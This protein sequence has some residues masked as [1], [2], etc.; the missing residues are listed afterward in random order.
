MNAPLCYSG[1]G[2]YIAYTAPRAEFEAAEGIREL[3]RDVYLPLEQRRVVRRNRRIDVTEPLFRRYVFFSLPVGD[4]EWGPVKHVDGVEDV[5]CNRGRASRVPTA[6]IER[7]RMLEKVGA[8][9]RTTP[10]TAYGI[11]ERVRVAEGPF[12]GLYA[13][14][15]EFI[16][17]MRSATARK[18]VKVLLN[19]LG[20]KSSIELDVDALEKL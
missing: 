5:L 12:T 4:D 2:W 6:A 10:L 14:I 9:N 13:E 17:K 16:H 15:E 1:P 3:G 19:F 11:G 20:R 7:L 8:F 18:R